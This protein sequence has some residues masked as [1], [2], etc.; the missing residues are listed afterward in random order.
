MLRRYD[1]DNDGT[2]SAAEFMKGE[3]AARAFMEVSARFRVTMAAGTQIR[4]KC[5]SNPWPGSK[6]SMAMLYNP[7]LGPDPGP[8]LDPDPN[9]DGSKSR[10]SHLAGGMDRQVRRRLAV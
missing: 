9:A 8:D 6:Y 4:L 1:A 7:D 3:T 5:N 2:I 10:W